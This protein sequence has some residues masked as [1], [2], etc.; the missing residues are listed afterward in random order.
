M[1]R[2]KELTDKERIQDLLSKALTKNHEKIIEKLIEQ[3]GI[4]NYVN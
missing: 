3:F 2:F 1:K 4:N